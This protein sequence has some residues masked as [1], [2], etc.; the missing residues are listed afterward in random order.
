METDRQT[1]RHRAVNFSKSKYV[2][3]NGYT[4]QYPFSGGSIIFNGGMFVNILT[5]LPYF[6]TSPLNNAWLS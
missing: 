5:G 6:F 1:D 3:I 4:H 2:K